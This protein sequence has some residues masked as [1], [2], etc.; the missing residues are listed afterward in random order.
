MLRLVPPDTTD[1]PRYGKFEISFRVDLA[2]DNPFSPDEIDLQVYFRTPTGLVHTMPGFYDEEDGKPAWKARYAPMELG[3]YR[4]YAVLGDHRT[5]EH[6]FECVPSDSDGFVRISEEDHRYFQ[7]DSGRPYFAVGH[8]VCWTHDYEPYFR[9]MAVHGENY[10]RIWMIHW[11]VALEW[12]GDGYPGLGRYHLGNAARLDHILDLA[13]QHGIY[14][15]LCFESFNNLRI[16][17]PYPAYQGNPYSRENGG[18]LERPEQFFTHPKARRL[19]KQRLR[20]LV[21]RYAYHPNILCWQFWNEVDIIETYV[22]DEV[23]EWHRDMARYLRSIDPMEHLVS[24]SF[25]NTKGDDALWQLPEMEYTQNHQYGSRD[26]AESIRTWTRRNVSEFGKP[27]LFGE[28]GSDAGGP[29]REW[30]PDGISLHNGI[31]SATLSGSAG[32]AMLWWWDNYIEPQNLYYHFR[33]LSQFVTGV[34]WPRANF[35]DAQIG[36]LQFVDPAAFDTRDLE[37]PCTV[38]WGHHPIKEYQILRDGSV[39]DNAQI[40]QFLYAPHS[41]MHE[42]QTFLVDYPED[43]HFAVYVNTVSNHGHLQIRLDGELVLDEALPVGPGKGPWKEARFRDE[44]G[45]YQNVYDRHYQVD[46]PA[47]PHTITVDN[48]GRDWIS[49]NA[50][51]FSNY[52][53]HE[54]PSLRVFGLQ[55]DT[56]AMLWLQNTQ[57]TWYRHHT[58]MPLQPVRPVHLEVL[59]LRDGEYAVEWWDTY[60]EGSVE[61]TTA[62]CSGGVLLL[63]TPEIEGDVACKLRRR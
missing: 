31:W 5:A 35:R 9:K 59:G 56:E 17:N 8:N 30:D 10:S 6:K 29:R 41:P 60:R 15:M 62:S 22:S 43:G 53:T 46:V 1:I 26:I 49:V 37:L 48:Q 61:H 39:E 28:Y 57:H 24:T 18:M 13:E 7:F 11:N 44:W 32:T 20:Y 34:D 4:Y 42:A 55:N 2:Y 45:I 27:H 16:R 63:S 50:Y 38:G 33:P 21:A 36:Q 40:T 54:R 51:R 12:S 14:L 47:G 3:V 52:Q 19:F 23:V 25:A 58:Q